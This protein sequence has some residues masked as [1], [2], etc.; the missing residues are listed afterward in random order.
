MRKSLVM[1]AVAAMVLAGCSQDN[2]VNSGAEQG[3]GTPIEFR[4][5]TNK[6]R[7]TESMDSENIGD[8][9]V[10]A[11]KDSN[12]EFDFMKDIAVIKSN[13]GSATVVWS[14]APLK[15]Y[16]TGT[17][18]IDFFAYSPSGSA[19]VKTGMT[20]VT[21]KEAALTY[22]VPLLG[23][24]KK[25]E[26][27]L[28]ATQTITNAAGKVAME[29]KHALSIATFAAKNV[30]KGMTLIVT[31]IE[32]SKL[33][34]EAELTIKSDGTHVWGTPIA[35]DQVY[36]LTLPASG[37]PVLPVLASV[38]KYQSLLPANEGLMVLP[39]A[40][41]TDIDFV[42]SYTA[43]DADN[44]VIGTN[45]ADLKI[46]GGMTFEMGKRYTFNFTFKGAYDPI[47]FEGITVGDW[48]DV[49]PTPVP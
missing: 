16:P 37:V 14:Y 24:T 40:V 34:V 31:G 15:F 45:Q 49:A 12:T 8:F 26:D 21:T 43:V 48:T 29:F 3:N 35:Q 2:V 46:V 19:N 36:G 42:I 20:S 25:A 39:Q 47:E 23:D 33:G 5:L 44:V 11:N 7:A 9:R 17:N 6:T 28:I 22:A 41:A 32:L 10:S 38:D 4:T 1:A 30:S 13:S 27:F 18:S